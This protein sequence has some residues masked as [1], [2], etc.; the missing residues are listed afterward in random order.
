M[1]KK[2]LVILFPFNVLLK[3][4]FYIVFGFAKRKKRF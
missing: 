4:L 3:V 1:F 2:K